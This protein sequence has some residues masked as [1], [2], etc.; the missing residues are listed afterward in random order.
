MASPWLQLVLL[1][2]VAFVACHGFQ[3]E[4]DTQLDILVTGYGPF[5]NFTTNP[6]EQLSRLL[7]QTCSKKVCFNS[8]VLPVNDEGSQVVSAMLQNSK[9]PCQYRA[10]LHMGLE[11]KARGL[12]IECM[13]ANIKAESKFTGFRSNTLLRGVQIVPIDGDAPEVLPTTLDLGH[14][15]LP[16]G[17]NGLEAFSRDA[18][19]F[20]CNQVYFNT[21]NIVRGKDIRCGPRGALLPVVFVHVPG[22]MTLEQLHALIVP[23]A[24]RL[25]SN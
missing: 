5:A 11:D 25:V 24:D 18:G 17:K 1:T 23:L 16:D 22:N 4:E 12:K 15:S 9:N 20:Y 21:L 2:V 7:N 19:S 14:F 10:V 13:A 3:Y 8:L 6:S